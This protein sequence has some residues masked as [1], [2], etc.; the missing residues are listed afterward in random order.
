[1]LTPPAVAAPGRPWRG[2]RE[3]RG[4]VLADAVSERW[5]H[6]GYDGGG[7]VGAVPGTG[8]YPDPP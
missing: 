3:R 8:R 1:L 6:F 2:R 5:K 7:K 4:L